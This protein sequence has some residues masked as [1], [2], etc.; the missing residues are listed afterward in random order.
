M[1]RGFTVI[2]FMSML[3]IIG[4]LI[5]AAWPAITGGH[6]NNDGTICKGGYKFTGRDVRA[7][8]ILDAEGH[9]I[10]CQTVR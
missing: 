3:A 6:S 7:T 2:E 9:G 4:I 8:Q 10:P 1:K 5:A